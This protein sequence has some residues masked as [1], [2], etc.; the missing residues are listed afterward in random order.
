M[1]ELH[2]WGPVFDAPSIDAECIAAITYLHNAN[3]DSLWRIIPSNDPSVSP[4][5]MYLPWLFLSS[6]SYSHLTLHL[7]LP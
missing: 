7:P 6:Y 3:R 1:L 4:A 5:S 2:V